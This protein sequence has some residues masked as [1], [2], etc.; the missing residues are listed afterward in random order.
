MIDRVEEENW[1][2]AKVPGQIQT[3]DVTNTN[4]FPADLVETRRIN[5][6]N[7][8]QAM[9]I[10]RDFVWFIIPVVYCNWCFCTPTWD[11]SNHWLTCNDQLVVG[12]NWSWSSSLS[13]SPQHMKK[14][15]IP[16]ETSFESNFFP[17]QCRCLYSAH[18][19]H[20]HAVHRG[21]QAKASITQVRVVFTQV[22]QREVSVSIYKLYLWRLCLL[23]GGTAWQNSRE[24]G[25]HLAPPGAPLDAVHIAGCF[26]F[27]ALEELSCVIFLQSLFCLLTGILSE[28]WVFLSSGGCF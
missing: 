25:I 2:S 28:C 6:A 4:D 17:R 27:L 24:I 5:S 13:S 7:T 16:C 18:F 12:V 1:Q 23:T 22:P 3:Q 20:M 9:L 10:T 19:C 14:L 15:M 8:I 26:K 21:N 11:T